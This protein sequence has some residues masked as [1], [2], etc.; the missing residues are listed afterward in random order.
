MKV[1]KKI[2]LSKGKFAKVDDEDFDKL[3]ELEDWVSNKLNMEFKLEDINSSKELISELQ[4]DTEVKNTVVQLTA[5]WT[6]LGT[7]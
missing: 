6:I 7:K 2:L 5:G 1:M 4:N 3:N